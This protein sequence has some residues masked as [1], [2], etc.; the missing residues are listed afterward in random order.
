VGESLNLIESREFE[1]IMIQLVS[2]DYHMAVIECYE[3]VIQ[4]KSFRISLAIPGVF[5]R[6]NMNYERL[7]YLKA[8][9]LWI[10]W[11]RRRR[12]YFSGSR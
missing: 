9:T 3:L 2:I 1:P 4:S 12:C 6:L 7:E 11:N 10:G 5:D 8:G